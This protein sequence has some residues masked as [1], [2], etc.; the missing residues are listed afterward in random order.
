MTNRLFGHLPIADECL[1]RLARGAYPHYYATYI[2]E[3]WGLPEVF[4]VDW[5]PIGLLW[6][7]IARPEL[8]SQYVTTVQS[9]PKS[10]LESDQRNSFLDKNNMVS[11]EGY[12][13]KSQRAIFNPGF[14]TSILMNWFLTSST[15]HWPFAM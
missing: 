5:L 10:P 12:K 2:R 7:F 11:A 14:S 4:Y 13:W 6:C 8:S 15:L 9:L 1:S 3:K